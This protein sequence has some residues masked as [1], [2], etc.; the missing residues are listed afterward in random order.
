MVVPLPGC[1]FRYG[2]YHGVCSL[3]VIIVDIEPAVGELEALRNR[4]VRFRVLQL[5][6]RAY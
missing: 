5:A 1:V 4:W 6:Y 3:P 2:T